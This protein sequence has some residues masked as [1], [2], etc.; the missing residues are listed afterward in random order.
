MPHNA[1]LRRAGVSRRQIV[2]FWTLY[3]TVSWSG[4]PFHWIWI[5]GC[6]LFKK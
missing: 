2:V 5:L 1:V 4:I 6:L 3:F